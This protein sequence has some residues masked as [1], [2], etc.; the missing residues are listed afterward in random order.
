MHEHVQHN[1]DWARSEIQLVDI[2]E[3]MQHYYSDPIRHE[4]MHLVKPVHYEEDL[5]IDPEN[6]HET[7]LIQPQRHGPYSIEKSSHDMFETVDPAYHY[8]DAWQHHMHHTHQPVH[9]YDYDVHHYESGGPEGQHTE[10]SQPMHHTFDIAQRE[11]HFD[12]SHVASNSRD[13]PYAHPSLD[14][15]MGIHGAPHHV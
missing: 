1:H 9:H 6:H 3:P 4:E 5:Y 15:Q 11:E 13:L 12:N 10:Y 2:V 8:D 7:L 14:M